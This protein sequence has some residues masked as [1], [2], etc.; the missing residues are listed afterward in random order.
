[1]P[2]VFI[3]KSLSFLKPFQ[4]VQTYTGIDISLP[5]LI[6]RP[7]CITAHTTATGRWIIIKDRRIVVHEI[8]L[9]HWNINN[10]EGFANFINSSALFQC[11]FSHI[12][13]VFSHSYPSTDVSMPFISHCYQRLL[14]CTHDFCKLV[15]IFRNSRQ[16]Y[17]GTIRKNIFWV[18]SRFRL[19]QNPSSTWGNT[20]RLLTGKRKSRTCRLLTA[21]KSTASKAQSLCLVFYALTKPRIKYFSVKIRNLDSGTFH[22]PD[23][24]TGNFHWHNPSGRTMAASVV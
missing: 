4:P 15:S 10:L 7:S 2:T 9:H 22:V 20:A 24:V 12:A 11:T 14:K 23:G 17:P 16:C 21:T 6:W 1:V 18:L 19:W 8:V 3:S 13:H 5:V